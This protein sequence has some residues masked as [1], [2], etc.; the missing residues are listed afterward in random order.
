MA[1]Q[2]IE[3]LRHRGLEGRRGERHTRKLIESVGRSGGKVLPST[4]VARWTVAATPRESIESWRCLQGL[5]GIPVPVNTKEQ[6]LS[7][8]ESWAKETFG[9]LD[10]VTDAEESYVLWPITVNSF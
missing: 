1:R 8:I 3:M 10:E 6:V 4:C 2:M 9:G 5:A 7:E